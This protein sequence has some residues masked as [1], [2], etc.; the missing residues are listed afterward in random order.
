[1]KNS[2]FRAVIGIMGRGFYRIALCAT[3]LFFA[4][5]S[6]WIFSII[7]DDRGYV[8]ILDFILALFSASLS[9]AGVF[10]IGMKHPNTKVSKVSKR[11]SEPVEEV[12]GKAV[13]TE[14]GAT[15]AE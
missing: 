10:S 8:A 5:A 14:E 4:G 11:K 7:P 1:M 6:C 2:I 9:L 12:Q 15:D 13:D 3:V